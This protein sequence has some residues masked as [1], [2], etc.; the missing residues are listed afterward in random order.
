MY[1]LRI[2]IFVK[3]CTV[4]KVTLDS[5]LMDTLWSCDK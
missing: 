2:F 3:V 1:F 5:C 4:L